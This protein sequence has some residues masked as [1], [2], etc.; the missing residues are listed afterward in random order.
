MPVSLQLVMKLQKLRHLTHHEAAERLGLPVADV[1]EAARMALLTMR[2]HDVEPPRPQMTDVERDALIAI[3]C[4]R[5]RRTGSGRRGGAVTV[6]DGALRAS[7]RPSACMG[8]VWQC[9]RSSPSI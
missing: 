1:R 7:V 8:V 5:R 9:S 6:D 3:A 2:D 4:R